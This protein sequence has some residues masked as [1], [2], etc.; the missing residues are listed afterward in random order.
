[1]ET[2][3]FS[4]FNLSLGLFSPLIPSLNEVHKTNEV[5]SNLGMKCSNSIFNA[6]W[7]IIVHVGVLTIYVAIGEV[8]KKKER[9]VQK[10]KFSLIEKIVHL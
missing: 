4:I 5:L 9:G 10:M 2:D 1:M 6:Q 8:F 7:I 3:N